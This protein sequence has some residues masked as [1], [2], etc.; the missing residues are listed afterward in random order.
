MN[1]KMEK[2]YIVNA[3]TSDYYSN[4]MDTE[5][6]FISFDREEA[7]KEGHLYFLKQEVSAVLSNDF[8]R[9]DVEEINIGQKLPASLLIW[10]SAHEYSLCHSSDI[11]KEVT[12]IKKDRNNI[13]LVWDDSVPYSFDQLR[14]FESLYKTPF[15]KIS[16]FN[17]ERILLQVKSSIANDLEEQLYRQ[18]EM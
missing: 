11:Q 7:I 1:N 17:R 4:Y 5:K 16:F 10:T 15:S 2:L 13:S 6:V 9:V 12:R 3:V 8:F 18:Y 14:E